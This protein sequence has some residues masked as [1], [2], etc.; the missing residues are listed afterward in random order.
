MTVG[1][2][3]EELVEQALERAHITDNPYHYCIWQVTTASGE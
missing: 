2:S 3:A 1:T